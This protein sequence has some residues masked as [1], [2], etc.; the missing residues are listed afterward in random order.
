ME[1]QVEKEKEEVIEKEDEWKTYFLSIFTSLSMN[2]KSWIFLGI[3]L[4]LLGGWNFIGLLSFAIGM[5]FSHWIHYWHHWEL[6]YPHNIIH[7]YHHRHNLPFNHWIQL[8]LELVSITGIILVKWNWHVQ[9]PFLHYLNEWIVLFFY[10]FYTT[11]HNVNYSIFHVNNVHEIHHREFVKNMGPDICDVL[12]GTKY[13]PEEGLENTDHYIPNLFFCTMVI[14]SLQ[15]IWKNS[16]DGTKGWIRAISQIGFYSAL[17]FLVVTSIVLYIGDL[18][19]GNLGSPL[20]PP[21]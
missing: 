7:D 10:L 1:K 14:L 9:L 21:Q 3:C 11:I 5:V 8:L 4:Y 12:F 15:M 19:E 20:T 18:H 2:Y 17:L 13:K 6:A 16:C